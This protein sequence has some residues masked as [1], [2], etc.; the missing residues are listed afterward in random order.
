MRRSSAR[1]DAL[2]LSAIAPRPR[3]AVRQTARHRHAQAELRG[4]WQAP[5]R[6]ASRRGIPSFPLTAPQPLLSFDNYSRAPPVRH[7]KYSG[8]SMLRVLGTFGL[9]I[10]FVLISPAL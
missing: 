6:G 2:P 9:G 8:L 4:R 3:R 1:A 10:L 5:L 7:H